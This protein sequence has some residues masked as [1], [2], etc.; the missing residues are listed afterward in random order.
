MLPPNAGGYQE[1]APV[2]VHDLEGR[3]DAITVNPGTIAAT[4][5]Q[6]I[7]EAARGINNLV[8]GEPYQLVT[9]I[10]GLETA[11]HTAGQYLDFPATEQPGEGDPP[12]ADKY[13]GLTLDDLRAEITKR[14]RGRDEDRRIAVS[15]TKAE[16]VA[17][18]HAD[19]EG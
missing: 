17:R 4:A 12:P 7:R 9:V 10:Q 13:E 18:L 3:F 6:A 11:A 8:D 19:D 5:V 14:N 16:L 2:G 15:G 1:E